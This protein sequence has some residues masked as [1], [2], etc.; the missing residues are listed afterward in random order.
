VQRLL[1]HKFQEVEN[2]RLKIKVKGK[3]IVV[4]EQIRKTILVVLSAKDFIGSAVSAEPHAALAWAG[5]CLIL[6]VSTKASST[7][8][9]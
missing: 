8:V 3:E 9:S 7:F 2:S 1:K 5:V 6:P 4:A